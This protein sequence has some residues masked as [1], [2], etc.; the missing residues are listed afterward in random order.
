[1]VYKPYNSKQ[2]TI[3]AVLA[4]CFLLS[5]LSVFFRM[6]TR[7]LT[8]AQLWWDDWTALL[9]LVSAIFVIHVLHRGILIIYRYSRGSRTSLFFS[10]DSL[11]RGSLVYVA[12]YHPR[13]ESRPR[14]A[15]KRP[16]SR[17]SDPVWCGRSSNK[18]IRAYFP[19]NIP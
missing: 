18:E 17:R 10:V 12:D 7:R 6:I 1:M 14:K 19:T 13:R 8:A 16:R 9:A 3:I 15:Y 5:T 2:I 11:S 4:V